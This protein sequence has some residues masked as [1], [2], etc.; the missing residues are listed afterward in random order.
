MKGLAYWTNGFKQLTSN[1]GPIKNPKDLKG[2]S[3]RIMQSDVIE[4]QFKQLGATPIQH[5]FNST[6]QLLESGKVDGEEN[7]ISNIYSKKFYNVQNYLTISNHGYLGYAVITGR[8]FWNKQ[9]P[10]TKR[11]VSEAMNETTVWNE[12]HSIQM[13]KDQ[14]KSIKESSSIKIYELDSKEKERWMET[15]D[16]VYENYSHVIGKE[17]TN[18]MR[19]LRKKYADH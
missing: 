16:P 13:N 9:S 19:A 18:K 12:Q 15:F 3:L 7:T 6:F 4:A 14:L 8:S 10:E 2:Q 11:I 1:K 5:S 17:L